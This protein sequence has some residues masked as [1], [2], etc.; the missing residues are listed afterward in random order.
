MQLRGFALV[1]PRTCCCWTSACQSLPA[2]LPSAW[3]QDRPGEDT[4]MRQLFLTIS[5]LTGLA[6]VA[7]AGPLPWTYTA[8]MLPT[9]SNQGILL[10][11]E[12]VGDQTFYNLLNLPS[13]VGD[14]LSSGSYREPFT[15]SLRDV[16]TST[17]LPA[18]PLAT[19]QFFYTMQLQNE[20]GDIGTV[21][22]LGFISADGTQTSGTGN[23]AIGFGGS[24]DVQVGQQT[25]RVTFGTRESET[26]NRLTFN[27]EVLPPS[28][29]T[30]EPGTLVLAGA[31]CVAGLMA[32]RRKATPGSPS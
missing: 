2:E 26:A 20:L 3:L 10:G 8:T 7:T 32:R 15:F 23:F 27:V 18:G 12:T 13:T 17:T 6:N 5:L 29:N 1:T 19:Q 30:P 24:E 4:P 28:I 31:A 25:A 14:S 21:S 22:M 11:Q 9:G 16:S